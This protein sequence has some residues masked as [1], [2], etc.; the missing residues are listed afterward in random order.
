MNISGLRSAHA[1]STVSRGNGATK[2]CA[3]GP[4]KCDEDSTKLSKPAELFAKL[5]Q[6]AKADPAKAK[7]LF[8]KIADRLKSESSD[9]GDDRLASLAGKFAEAAKTGDVS[10]LQPSAS[11]R[12][13]PGPSPDGSVLGGA[14]HKQ[15][16]AYAAANQH[17]KRE[18]L[19]ASM[20][21]DVTAA[22]SGVKTTAAAS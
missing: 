8:G 13:P 11:D 7:N 4:G 16:G 2:S 9:G 6:L 10:S 15:V 19:F 17:H 3:D 1:P 18:D 21:A 5:E 22:L 20:T 12:P 14:R